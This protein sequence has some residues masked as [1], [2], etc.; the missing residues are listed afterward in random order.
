MQMAQ[1]QGGMAHPT[2][3]FRAQRL[4]QNYGLIQGMYRQIK[5]QDSVSE[6]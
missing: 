5:I 4:G 3:R 6:S 1:V 2:G